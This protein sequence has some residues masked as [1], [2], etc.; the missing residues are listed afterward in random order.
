MLKDG[1]I[2]NIVTIVDVKDLSIWS[3]DYSKLTQIA[4]IMG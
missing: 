3:I 2:E 1:A 4:K